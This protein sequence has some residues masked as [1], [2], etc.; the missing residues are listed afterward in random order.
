MGKSL[1]EQSPAAK[2]VFAEAD[3][4]TG[5]PLTEVCFN[6]PAETLTDTEFAQPGV[7]A[8][9]LAAARA[10][11]ER[12]SAEGVILSP[13]YCAG[14]SVG[15]LAALTYAGALTL[16]DGLSLVAARGRLMAG[17]SRAANGTMAAV[18][19][20]DEA[21]LSNVCSEASTQ[22]G[23]TVQMA[24]FNAPGQL[25][26][27]GNRLAVERASELARAAGAKRVIPLEVS[28]PFHSI[29]MQPAADGFEPVVRGVNL[30]TPSVPVVLNLSGEPSTDPA[31]IRGELVMQV[32]S[33]V[34][35]SDSVLR[36]ADAGCTHFIELGPGQVLSGLVKRTAK[37][38]SVLNVED[39]TSLESTARELLQLAE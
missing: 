30:A 13:S 29:Y 23:A 11:E 39:G 33:A 1:W 27:S 28:G 24:N 32:V 6:G 25:V 7:V 37:D 4:A 3:R 22:A 12:L 34:R 36:M 21:S 38:V 8:V 19:G 18:L 9:S 26:I 16:A 17:A 2:Q 5:L 31:E 35:W 10:L 14:H 20:M 15:E